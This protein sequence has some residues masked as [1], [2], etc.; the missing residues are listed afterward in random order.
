MRNYL[1]TAVLAVASIAGCKSK[2]SDTKNQPAPDNTGRN[3]RER[4]AMPVADEAVSA[5]GDLALTTEIRK[6]VV[7]DRSLSM[8]A[9][10][11]KIVVNN[12]VVTLVGP[13]KTIAERDR[14]QQ[15]ALA[16]VGDDQKVL[17]KLEVVTNN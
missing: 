5:P 14:V 9:H 4:E 6:A 13:V 8:D 1:F 10:N 7:D 12:G 16:V 11:C 15:L 2:Q 17:N 3:A